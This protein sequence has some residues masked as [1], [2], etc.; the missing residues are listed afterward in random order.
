VWCARRDPVNADPAG[1]FYCG[2]RRECGGKRNPYRQRQVS[3]RNIHRH[4][5]IVQTDNP[6]RRQDR[7]Q[8]NRTSFSRNAPAPNKKSHST[9]PGPLAF[10][11][12]LA[13][14]ITVL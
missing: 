8:N 1:F 9:H 7:E 13:A 5:L 4:Q 14:D 6:A 2:I 10:N 3:H 12:A 11:F